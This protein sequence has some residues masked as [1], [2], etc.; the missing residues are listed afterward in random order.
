MLL[1]DN[2]AEFRNA[3]STEICSQYNIKQTFTVAYHPE[4]NELVER[5]NRKILDALPPVVNNLQDNWEDW[6]PQVTACMNSSINESTGK[7]P[8]YIMYGVDKRLPYDLLASR[9]KAVYNICIRLCIAAA[10]GFLRH[11]C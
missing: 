5:A 1:S 6:L 8:H 2:G 3:M 11:S 10:T 4:S 7:S 9:R